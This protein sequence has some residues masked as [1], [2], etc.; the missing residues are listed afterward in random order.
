MCD[1]GIW[2]T[3]C[4]RGWGVQEATVVCRQL[5][6]SGDLNRKYHIHHCYIGIIVVYTLIVKAVA[7]RNVTVFGEGSGSGNIVNVMWNCNGAETHL[8]NCSMSSPKKCNH[9][10]DAGVYC[11]GNECDC[12]DCHTHNRT[13]YLATP[14]RKAGAFPQG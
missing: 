13:V 5:G 10:R 1:Q 9:D 2:K 11:F 3:V 12:T 4:N 14:C 8:L 7:E 6:F